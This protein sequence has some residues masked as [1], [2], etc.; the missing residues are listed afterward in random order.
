MNSGLEGR[1]RGLSLPAFLQMSE[2]EENT[3]TLRISSNHHAEIGFLYLLNGKL[4]AAETGS[5]Q[6]VEAAYEIIR[7]D[8][9]VIDI[10]TEMSKRNDEINMP[11]MNILMDSLRV[12]DEHAA[13]IH[14]EEI[15]DRALSTVEKQAL[16]NDSDWQDDELTLDLEVD[17]EELTLDDCF[18]GI[19]GPELSLPAHPVSNGFQSNSRIPDEEIDKKILAFQNK[20][21]ITCPLCQ[22]GRIFT[23]Q[24]NDGNTYYACSNSKCIF[25]SKEKPYRFKCPECGNPFLIEKTN[26]GSGRQGLQCPKA[27]CPY[28]QGYL[29]PPCSVESGADSKKKYRIVR[30]KKH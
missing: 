5:L 8:D 30:K 13:S 15:P 28:E 7:W 1:I 21:A 16:P 12:K 24:T 27:A 29:G 25:I 11:L 2:M 23:Q 14:E 10:E 18:D 22:K 17:E 26:P 4:I 19:D 9:P 6:A 20:I 3:C